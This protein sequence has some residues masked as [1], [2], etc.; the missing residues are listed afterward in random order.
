MVG[1]VTARVADHTRRERATEKP[2]RELARAGAELVDRPDR[3]EA[4][5]R[6]A[7]ERRGERDDGHGP[8]SGLDVAA[9]EGTRKLRQAPHGANVQVPSGRGYLRRPLP[10]PK[11]RRSDTRSGPEGGCRAS[12]TGSAAAGGAGALGR[13]WLS[14]AIVVATPR[15]RRRAKSPRTAASISRLWLCSFTLAGGFP[16]G[17]RSPAKP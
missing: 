3:H 6:R 7:G 4:P 11:S 17:R 2:H 5:E 9:D 8:Q 13:L 10:R 1:E 16:A 15:A 12:A 14:T